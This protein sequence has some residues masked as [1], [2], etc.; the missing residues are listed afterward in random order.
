MLTGFRIIS[1]GL[2]SGIDTV[3]GTAF[4]EM[5]LIP[6]YIV[7]AKVL[8]CLTYML[9]FHPQHLLALIYIILHKMKPLVFEFVKMYTI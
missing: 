2:A 7:L 1:P 6:F 5:V 8:A 3:S 4:Q 9:C